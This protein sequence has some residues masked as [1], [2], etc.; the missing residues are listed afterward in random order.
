MTL[1]H[2]PYEDVRSLLARMRAHDPTL[3]SRLGLVVSLQ[4]RDP[5]RS[6]GAR[7]AQLEALIKALPRVS[8]V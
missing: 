1:S 7:L 4:T 2:L 3:W 5:E 6:Y 8:R